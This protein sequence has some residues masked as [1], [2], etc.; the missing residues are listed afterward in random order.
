[1]NNVE[2]CITFLSFHSEPLVSQ[3]AKFC[4]VCVSLYSWFT[5]IPKSKSVV[6]ILEKFGSQSTNM[7]LVYTFFCYDLFHDFI[8]GFQYPVFICSVTVA[9]SYLSGLFIDNLLKF[10]TVLRNP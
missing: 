9:L 2:R 7:W 5:M 4:D 1:M 3:L 6:Y 10:K 8:Y